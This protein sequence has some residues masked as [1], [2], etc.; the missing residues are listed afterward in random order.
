MP[1]A[2][3]AAIPP[4]SHDRLTAMYS[5]ALALGGAHLDQ[6]GEAEREL[7][8][9]ALFASAAAAMFPLAELL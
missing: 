7:T 9:I 6:D 1:V 5:R 8:P 3:F 4:V 2:T